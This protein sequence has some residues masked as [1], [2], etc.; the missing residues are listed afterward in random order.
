MHRAATRPTD[1]ER[2]DHRISATA[3]A[4]T[5][6]AAGRVTP[7]GDR[8]LVQRLPGGGL[9]YAL[10]DDAARIEAR[11]LRKDHGQLYAEVTVLVDW[12]GV[13][14]PISSATLN[15]SSQTTRNGLASYCARRS[16]SEKTFDWQDAIDSACIAI[17]EA[18]RQGDDPIVLDDA[19]DVEDRDFHVHGL[20]IPADARSM[21]IAHGDS[22]KSLILLFVLGTLAKLGYVV[23]LL[24]W[25]WT[26]ARHKARKRRMFGCERL[27]H[28]HYLRCHAPLT[29]RM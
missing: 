14:N 9:A 19:V 21:L 23:L 20:T 3:I 2:A 17:I 8:R 10:L 1:A 22:L 16:K 6:G 7:I 25:E 11:Y 29:I 4:R 27:E 28:L 15:L 5:P 18:D 24:D 26:G 12:A 13:K